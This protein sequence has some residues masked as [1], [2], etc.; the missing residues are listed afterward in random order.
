MHL[1]MSSAKRRL[2]GSGLNELKLNKIVYPIFTHMI[3]S[4]SKSSTDVSDNYFW[5]IFQKKGVI[6]I[7]TDLQF[8]SRDP[9]H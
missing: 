4:V 2:F 6:K 3:G 9:F 8:R 5:L 1:K 7:Y